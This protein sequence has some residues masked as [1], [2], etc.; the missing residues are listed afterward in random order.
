MHVAAE[1]SFLFGQAAV[2]TDLI[3]HVKADREV[4]IFFLYRGYLV[5]EARLLPVVGWAIIGCIN[6]LPALGAYI[7]SVRS[8]FPFSVVV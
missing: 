7:H 8:G 3:H 5:V 6:C 2:L 1:N 4:W